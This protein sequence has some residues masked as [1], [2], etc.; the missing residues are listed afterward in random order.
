MSGWVATLIIV[1]LQVLHFEFLHFEFLHF[2]F[3]HFE[4]LTFPSSFR[5]LE[6]EIGGFKSCLGGWVGGHFDYSVSPGPSF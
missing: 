3:L 5:P 6:A 2:E 4:F 1:S